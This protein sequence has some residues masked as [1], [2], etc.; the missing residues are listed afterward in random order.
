MP[1]TSRGV[2]PLFSEQAIA[3]GVMLPDQTLNPY[4]LELVPP[5]CSDGTTVKGPF[6]NAMGNVAQPVL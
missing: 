2:E 4:Q 1:A 5:Y 6:G 3:V